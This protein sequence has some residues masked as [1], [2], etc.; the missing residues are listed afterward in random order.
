MSIAGGEWTTVE[1]A[2]LPM[3][4]LVYFPDTSV[5]KQDTG[6]DDPLVWSSTA[7]LYYYADVRLDGIAKKQSSP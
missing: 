7:V 1:E 3:P 5:G 4:L 2:F 6:L